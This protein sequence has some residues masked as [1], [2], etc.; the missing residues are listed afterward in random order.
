M[1]DP[2]KSGIMD[3]VRDRPPPTRGCWISMALVAIIIA[4]VAWRIMGG[5]F[6]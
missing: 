3:P 4:L 2:N 1:D 5:I 6:K